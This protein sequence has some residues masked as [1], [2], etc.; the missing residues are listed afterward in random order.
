MIYLAIESA[1]AMMSAILKAVHK[2]REDVSRLAFNPLCNIIL[3]LLQ[4]PTL[5]T[6]RAA[7]GRVG[8]VNASAILCHVEVLEN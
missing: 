5:G 1:D 8:G 3:N 6:I 7:F 4:L 2:Q